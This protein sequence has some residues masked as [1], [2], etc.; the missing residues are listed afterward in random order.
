MTPNPYVL[1]LTGPD[2]VYGWGHY[3]HPISPRLLDINWLICTFL[4]MVY[5]LLRA[6]CPT[7]SRCLS[8]VCVFLFGLSTRSI[9]VSKQEILW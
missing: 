5:F 2:P 9:F 7:F 4:V 3:I 6:I 1:R 8:V